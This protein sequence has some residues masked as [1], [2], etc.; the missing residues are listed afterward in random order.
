MLKL[1]HNFL[2]IEYTT[3]LPIFTNKEHTSSFD[4]DFSIS[5]IRNRTFINRCYH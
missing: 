1:D 3:I 2:L 4:F 5:I